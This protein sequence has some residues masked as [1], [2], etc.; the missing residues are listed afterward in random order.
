MYAATHT[1]TQPDRHLILQQ[2]Q[3]HNTWSGG[4]VYA[5][6][7]VRTRT[8]WKNLLRKTHFGIKPQSG[9]I[10][11]RNHSS[12]SLQKTHTTTQFHFGS[13][14]PSYHVELSPYQGAFNFDLPTRNTNT[15][16]FTACAQH[17]DWQFQCAHFHLNPIKH[18]AA[19]CAVQ[20]IKFGRGKSFCLIHCAQPTETCMGGM[21]MTPYIFHSINAV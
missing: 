4:R 5:F 7:G 16:K 6:G 18:V 9:I 15:E 1:Y 8:F 2:S 17:L 10:T 13:S 20:P 19:S 3:H 11:H 14:S 21:P 12:T